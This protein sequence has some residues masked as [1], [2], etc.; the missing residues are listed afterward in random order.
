M[1]NITQR[2]RVLSAAVVMT[3]LAPIAAVAQT[4]VRPGF[5]LF[6]AQQD[7]QIGQQSAAQIERQLPLVRSQ[8][9]NS[10]VSHIGERLVASAPG[11][12]FDYRF[13]VVDASDI[14]AFALPGG[15]IYVNRGTIAAAHNEGELAGVLA[16]EI[17]HDALRHGTHNASRAYLTQAGVGILGG[18]LGGRVGPNTAQIINIAGGLGLNTLFLRYSRAS[19]SEADI[20]GAQIMAR[21]GYDPRDMADFFRT[22]QSTDRRQTVQ[23]LSDHP[24]PSSRVQRVEREASLIGA[25]RVAHYRGNSQLDRVQS[26]LASM[27]PAATTEQI[28]R[29]SAA[30]AR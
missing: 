24:N 1:Q 3:L 15:F 13:R 25:P 17:A 22:I 8:S 10:Y 4:Q 11:P 19:E 20:L 6:S 16:H 5:N 28:V 23:W 26:T 2:M 9:V 27:R 30:R 12:R 18:L 7:V 29:R 21:A 14:N